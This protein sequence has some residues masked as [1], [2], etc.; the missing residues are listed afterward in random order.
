MLTQTHLA[1]IETIIAEHP[2]ED[3][4]QE[5]IACAKKII[6]TRKTK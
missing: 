4:L 1:L 2:T 6:E 5:L 3:C